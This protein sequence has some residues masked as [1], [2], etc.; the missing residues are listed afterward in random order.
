MAAATVDV[1]VIVVG[2][3]GSGLAAAASAARLGRK[4]VLIEK[5]ATP[6]GSTAWSV[7]SV[8][9]NRS[10]HQKRVG[11]TD[12]AQEHFEDLGLLA[13]AKVDRDN[14]ALRR[15]LV[16]NITETFDWLLSTGLV[17]TGPALEPPHRYPRMHNVL[18]NSRA[19]PHALA[20]HC[21]ALGVDIRTSLAAEQIIRDGDRVSGLTARGACG[22]AVQFHARHG[23][24]LAT[25]DYGGDRELKARLASETAGKT[26]AV[27]PT[28]T[29][30]GHKIAL[31][32]GACI[33]NGDIVHGPRLRF[34]PPRRPNLIRLLPP[35]AL[36]AHAA[37]FAA[38]KL[39]AALLRPFLMSFVTTALGVEANLYK[40]GAILVNALGERFADEL[41]SPQD[42]L[43]DQPDQIAYV[44]LDGAIA[45]TFSRWPNFIST[46][47]GVAYA[48]IDDY[49]RN[50]R[51]I[52]H[53]AP[54]PEALAQRIGVPPLQL[55]QTMAARGTLT[56]APYIALGPIKP[57]VV[58][59]DGGLRVT[60]QLEVVGAGGAP[61]PGLYAAGSTGQ[62]GL[63]LYGHGHHLAWAFVSGRI[64]GR[65]AALFGANTQAL[66]K[67]LA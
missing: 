54:T 12:S 16:E 48:Y 39:P 3:G 45:E 7:G 43:P 10:P 40:H 29:G 1:D 63:L 42:A 25:G 35:N 24:V 34:V 18:P 20:R 14:L 33:V 8:S 44:I 2:G 22:Q 11:I 58:L 49:R 21:R 31:A 5:N 37:K 36:I 13:G 59:T 67:A 6:G 56:R 46:A 65:N 51:D 38:E 17:F 60:E 61:I 62:G 47:P 50:R 30:D 19:F 23:I 27:N 28:N 15:I 32:L 55:A 26:S 64:A 53:T 4:V 66:G 41:G 9:V 57:Y 52:F